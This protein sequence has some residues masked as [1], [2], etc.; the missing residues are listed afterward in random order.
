MGN[1][2]L[3]INPITGQVE[4]WIPANDLNITE[5]WSD[6]VSC[7]RLHRNNQAAIQFIADM[8]EA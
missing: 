4:V 7:L 3:Q 8:I 2:H 6:I 5:G 1:F